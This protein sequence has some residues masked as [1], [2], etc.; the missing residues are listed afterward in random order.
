MID[1]SFEGGWESILQWHGFADRAKQG[2][3]EHFVIVDYG[4]L[5]E[6][7]A[8]EQLTAL[9][10]KVKYVSVE[11]VKAVDFTPTL[12]RTL[13][14]REHGWHY[15]HVM[16]RCGYGGHGIMIGANGGWTGAHGGAGDAGPPSTPD[17][18]SILYQTDYSSL[19]IQDRGF[20]T[21]QD[22]MENA[23][24]YDYPREIRIVGDRHDPDVKALTQAVIKLVGRRA[25]KVVNIP[26]ADMMYRPGPHRTYNLAPEK[27]RE[28]FDIAYKQAL[29]NLNKAAILPYA[30]GPL[31]SVL[32]SKRKKHF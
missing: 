12:V 24:P 22:M 23:S 5:A 16:G 8:F 28:R 27:Y 18:G 10:E 29:E 30:R 6:A 13:H 7:A 9:A 2:L 4:T 11:R 17:D 20:T 25:I 15:C 32:A 1:R 21:L 3:S 14:E 19:G 31:Q 26:H